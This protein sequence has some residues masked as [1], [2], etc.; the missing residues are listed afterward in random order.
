MI[1]RGKQPRWLRI[2]AY[3]S[4]GCGILAGLCF[5]PFAFVLVLPGAIILL[6]ESGAETNEEMVDSF[7]RRLPGDGPDQDHKGC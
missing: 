2:A 4:L 5:T 6:M 7:R 3:A 1:F